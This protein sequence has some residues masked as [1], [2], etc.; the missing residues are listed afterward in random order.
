MGKKQETTFIIKTAQACGLD[1]SMLYES[2]VELAGE[3]LLTAGC[4]DAAAG[5]LLTELG[6]PAY[7]FQNL[8]KDALKRLLHSIATTIQLED[9]R[10]VLR[11]EVSEVR[12][13][14]EGGVQVR[15]ATPKNRDRMEAVLDS[16]MSGSRIEYYYGRKSRY[17]TYIIRPEPCPSVED[18][19]GSSPFAFSRAVTGRTIPDTTRERYETFLQRHNQ[20]VIPL[21]DVSPAKPTREIRVMFRDDFRHS[22]LPVL[23]RML[24]DSKITLTRAYWETYR[25]PDGRI[26][27]ICSLYLDDTVKK[28]AL[29]EA[30]GRLRMFLAVQSDHYG[31]LF[32]NGSLSFEEYIFTILADAFVHIFVHK[33]LSAD[34]EIMAE[35]KRPDLKD[36]FARRIY[37]TNRAEYT[38]KEITG[39][40]TRHPEL[41][42]Q[43]FRLFDRRFN[44]VIARRIS[45]PALKKE[46]AAFRQRA[47][48]AFV[49]DHTGRDVFIFMTRLIAHGLKT[50]F[51]QAVKRS[52][53]FRLDASVLDPLVFP[54]K[55]HGIFFTVGFHS[56]GTHMRA[57]DV[58]RGGLRLVRVT[59]GNYEN[60]LDDMA[61][62]NYALGAV[63]QRLKHKDIA[64]SGAKGVI[65]PDPEYARDSYNA[66][67]DFTEAVMDLVQPSR[68]V[69]DYLGASERVF[70]GPDEGT[71]PLMDAIAERARKR[72]DRYWRTVTTGKTIG[73]P[74]D[75]YGLTADGQVFGLLDREEKGTE[76]EVDGRTVLVSTDM[77][78][79]YER[80]GGRIDVSGMTTNGVMSCLQTVLDHLGMKEPDTNLM[81][82]G[83]PDGDLGANQIQSYRGRI[84][85]VIDGG[86]VLFDPDGL[87]RKELMKVALARHTHPRLNSLAYPEGCLGRRGFKMPRKPGAF[88][89]PGGR[90]I[91]DGAYYHRYFL[92]DPA[93]RSL[94][95]EADIRAFVPCG[96]FM[97]TINGENV[98]AF[99]DV[100]RELKVIVEGANVFFDDT[101]RDVIARETAILQIR[102]SSANKGG[103]TS[104]AVAEV[105][106]AFLLGEDYEKVL[107][108]DRRTRSDFIREIFR[109]IS[110]NARA[111]TRMLLA[112]HERTGA[113]LYRLSVETSEH[114][115]ALQSR[116]YGKLDLLLASKPLTDAVLRAYIP[117]VLCEAVG[118]AGIRRILS[119]P[120]L[121]AY[122]DAILT[123]K[124]AAAALYRHAADWED[125]LQRLEEDLPG[126][127]AK[128][129][130]N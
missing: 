30:I 108:R 51:Y 1:A 48:I 38:R 9:G 109:L 10:Y 71:A 13:D 117:P 63:A 115:L 107:V 116:L 26:E 70:F 20:S 33:D 40:I 15:I 130:R 69:V 96:G 7:F 101:A 55:V 54:A 94:V 100:F 86:A 105:L 23:R 89:L 50:N 60:E 32:L 61:L 106:P 110:V 24:E 36:A 95:A 104:S 103:V 28:P 16:A 27:S 6:L 12:F 34:G 4:I 75:T 25:N 97:N 88:R 119:R 17:F 93:V 90:T 114:L 124:I 19:R 91:A 65:V 29:A 120:E 43:L 46:L 62:L 14:M 77:D 126:T 11:S 74:H 35:L 67:L 59:A 87:D 81:M 128:I 112:L 102:D 76:L 44:P 57:A 111:E 42:K 64:E 45:S 39:V 8:S 79:I 123:K 47:A 56:V 83:G 5:I 122:R 125:F 21:V 98:R 129:L 53:G 118:L 92:T 121:A 22:P 85:L 3:G 127:V 37:E 52:F 58:A 68:E 73:I 2:V 113:P 80:I 66:V 72:G 99:L 78:R 49:D 84:C 18:C 31:D 82:T 41:M